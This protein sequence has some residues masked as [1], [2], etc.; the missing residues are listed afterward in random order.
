M[1]TWE[2]CSCPRIPV[3]EFQKLNAMGSPDTERNIANTISWGGFTAA[4]LVQCLAAI[5]CDTIR[6]T[7]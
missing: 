4:F 6:V 5:G 7:D 3:P 1:S 2:W